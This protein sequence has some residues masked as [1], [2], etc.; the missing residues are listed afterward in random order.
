MDRLLIV[1]DELENLKALRR[2][3]REWARDHDV[4]IEVAE[5]GTDALELTRREPCGVILSDNRMPGISGADLV[6]VVGEESPETVSIIIT[7]Y[8]EK[9]DIEKALSSGIFAFM[10]KPWDHE[11][12]VENLGGA[13]TEHRRRKERR[14]ST[15]K[16]SEKLRL[17]IAFQKEVLKIVPPEHSG[18]V[19]PSYAQ[20]NAGEEGILG[21]YLD[22]VGIGG[23]RYLVLLGDISGQGLRTA[24]VSTLLKAA[25]VPQFLSQH[26]H[27]VS[28][29]HLLRWLNEKLY[30]IVA[31]F[32]DLFVALNATVVD[33]TNRSIT[34]AS[35]G[36][37]LPLV[38]RSHMLRP[39]E[40]PGVA[41]GINPGPDYREQTVILDPGEAFYLFTDGFRLSKDGGDR[42]ERED[43]IKVL[44]ETRHTDAIERAVE[45]LMRTVD[46]ETLT[47][48]FSIVRL[49][50]PS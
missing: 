44:L 37:P 42:A 2:E 38:Q 32:D 40:V 21:D 4:A 5:N 43:L 8:T 29:A 47:D 49:A 22:L 48:D 23:N 30:T 36:L 1:D 26:G 50:A 39:L 34:S 46:V 14:E 24:F 45:R 27:D 10:V 28:P 7:G 35:A 41:L 17:A 20:F 15:R 13:L 16:S 25:L 6:R 31:D 11:K 3:L 18:R 12:L 9:G 33:E 19:V